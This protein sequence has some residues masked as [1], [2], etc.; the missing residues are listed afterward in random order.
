MVLSAETP[1]LLIQAVDLVGLA[2][3]GR[4]AELGEMRQF[5]R[6]RRQNRR[7]LRLIGVVWSTAARNS[8]RVRWQWHL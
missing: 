8:W 1:E 6:F 4:P 7:S 5:Q 2:K 3:E